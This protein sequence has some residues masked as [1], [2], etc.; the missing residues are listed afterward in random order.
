MNAMASQITSLTI[1][2][3]TVYS[4]AVQRKH[5]SS[6]SLAFVRGIHRWT[7]NSPHIGQWRRKCFHFMTSSWISQALS[8]Y[9]QSLLGFTLTSSMWLSLD[10]TIETPGIGMHTASGIMWHC[11]NKV[12]YINADRF[13]TDIY[14]YIYIC[15]EI[16]LWDIYLAVYNKYH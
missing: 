16:N 10:N 3:S 6:A 13:I 2:Y 14:I 11:W 8:H 9:R 7:M 5:Q 4:S 15:M 12:R 1:V